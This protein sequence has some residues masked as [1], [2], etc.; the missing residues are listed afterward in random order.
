MLEE[1][2]L[3]ESKKEK[4]PFISC[5]TC[6]C[7]HLGVCILDDICALIVFDKYRLIGHK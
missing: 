1:D 4:Y 7:H 3:V 5:T 6:T 2:E